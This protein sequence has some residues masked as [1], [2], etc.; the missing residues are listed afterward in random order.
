MYF[1]FAVSGRRRRSVRWLRGT[2]SPSASSCRT[3]PPACSTVRSVQ[4]SGNIQHLSASFEFQGRIYCIYILF[5]LF[6]TLARLTPPAVSTSSTPPWTA[7]RPSASFMQPAVERCVE[8][9]RVNQICKNSINITILTE[10]CKY[11]LIPTSPKHINY[12]ANLL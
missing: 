7:N 11:P 6:I 8:L 5:N 12:C 2:S 1:L 3:P 10:L 4:S 9:L